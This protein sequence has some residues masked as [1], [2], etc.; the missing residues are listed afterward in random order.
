MTLSI[1]I[2]I[3]IYTPYTP[4]AWLHANPSHQRIHRSRRRSDLKYLDLQILRFYR[5][6]FWVTGTPVT[7]LKPRL[8]FGDSR[9]NVSD[10]Y[11]DSCEDLLEILAVVIIW[12]LMS[13]V[14]GACLKL[15]CMKMW[16]TDCCR[17]LQG[18]AGCCSID[19]PYVWLHIDSM[20][21]YNIRAYR[22]IQRQHT[23]N[24]AS[25]GVAGCC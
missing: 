1:Y 8:K 15:I 25:H 10:M 18:V 13:S 23:R 7:H 9:E 11:G 4:Y 24:F 12:R 20:H 5:K 3:Y 21:T 6:L 2:Y 14:C 22:H 19:I 16:F 17:V